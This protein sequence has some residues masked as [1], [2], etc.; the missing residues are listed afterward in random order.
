MW[1][2]VTGA[3]QGIANGIFL[4]HGALQ[5]GGPLSIA[6]VDQD[7]GGQADGWEKVLA[8]N[9][10]ST[11][12]LARSA[13]DHRARSSVPMAANACIASVH[14]QPNVAA[15]GFGKAAVAMAW[16]ATASDGCVR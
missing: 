11:W 6:A 13:R 16:G 12:L 1:T 3:A 14:A 10:L 8:V 7:I 4:A 9:T 15:T 2:S 5:R